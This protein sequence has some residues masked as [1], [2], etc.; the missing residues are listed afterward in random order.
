M[1]KADAPPKPIKLP[2]GD[3]A[4]ADLLYQTRAARYKLQHE[5]AKLEATEGAIE[6]YFI[7]SLS[8]D[9]TGVA[10]KLGRVQIQLKTIPV[11]E[12]WP[13]FYAHVKKTGNFELLQRRLSDG[14]VKERW[15]N[16]KDVPGV[17]KLNIKKVSC[18]QVK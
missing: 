9:S 5:V 18:T 4:K 13:K 8:K 7:N 2:K 11:V 10:G 3:G 16:K 17:S 14:A 1:A 15:E 12:D 6:D